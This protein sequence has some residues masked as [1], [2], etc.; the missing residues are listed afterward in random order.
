MYQMT[1]IT[2][3]IAHS[4]ISLNKKERKKEKIRVLL[5]YVGHDNEL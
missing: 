3:Y 2:D 1:T 4:I 5:L